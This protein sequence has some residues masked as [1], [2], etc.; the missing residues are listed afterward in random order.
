MGDFIKSTLVK[1]DRPVTI[2][3]DE[4]GRGPVL[5]YLVYC[6]M[7]F[8]EDTVVHKGFKDSKKISAKQREAMACHLINNKYE[9]ICKFNHPDSIT[10]CMVSGEQNLNQISV[11][12]VVELLSAITEN[13]PNIKTVYIDA[14]GNCETYKKL[15]TTKFNHKFVIEQKA[16]SKFPIVSAAS[17]MAKVSRDNTLEEFGSGFGSGYPGDPDTLKWLKEKINKVFGFPTGVRHSW[18]TITNLLEERKSKE[19]TG[20]LKGFYY[21]PD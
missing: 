1:S 7:V 3:I 21:S 19:Y 17:I 12:S 8:Y 16:D 9:F 18:K 5:G 10:H 4:A 15:L 6:A 13:Y 20:R 2:G 11:N 14:L